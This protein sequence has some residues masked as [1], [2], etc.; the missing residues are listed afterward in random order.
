MSKPAELE[1][2][3]HP[4]RDARVHSEFE[5]WCAQILSKTGSGK[6]SIEFDFKEG[7]CQGMRFSGST[8][9]EVLYPPAPRGLSKRAA[10]RIM[11]GQDVA[12]D[13][14][15][16]ASPVRQEEPPGLSRWRVASSASITASSA[17][18]PRVDGS[19]GSNPEL[20]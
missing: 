6:V 13:R 10:E 18:A 12:S 19:S 15:T 11:S 16:Q 2:T 17:S 7:R 3:E 9:R 14:E 8:G 1:H 20:E 4:I 5:R